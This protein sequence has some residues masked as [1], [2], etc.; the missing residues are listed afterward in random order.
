[1]GDMLVSKSY[2]DYIGDRQVVF[3]KFYG[4]G[5]FYLTKLIFH[6]F[7]IVR[8]IRNVAKGIQEIKTERALRTWIM[9]FLGK[10][11]QGR[12]E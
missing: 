1:H 4:Y 8:S 6:P 2:S 11:H 12:T 5:C 10:E 3:L 9:R 7:K